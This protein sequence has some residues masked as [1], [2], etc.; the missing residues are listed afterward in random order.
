MA[1]RE[2]II[3]PYA[4]L[5]FPNLAKARAFEGSDPKFGCALLF[6][7]P[8]NVK[9]ERDDGEPFSPWGDPTKHDL[10]LLHEAVDK[11]IAETWPN[12][13][14]RPKK[15]VV[16]FKDGDDEKWDGYAGHFFIRTTS[17]RQPKL[18]DVRKKEVSGD[19]IE[20]VFYPGAW[21]RAIVNVFDYNTAGNV[22]VSFG[23]QAVQFVRDDKP[24]TGGI[25]ADAFD[26][27][28]DNDLAPGDLD[29]LG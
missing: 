28:P 22:G 9:S 5:S 18:V 26:D 14:K 29:D 24:F 1:D 21:V 20:K 16:P 8:E 23:L 4:R 13:K 2:V 12:E 6:P 15:L 17:V 25:S 27:L 7:K 10:A 3:T 19:E 11:H